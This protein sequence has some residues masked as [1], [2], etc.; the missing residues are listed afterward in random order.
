MTYETLESILRVTGFP[1]TYHHWAT[2]PQPPYL[3]YLD[4]Y[5]DNFGADDAVYHEVTHFLIELYV[6]QRDRDL[7][8]KVEAALD[9]AG[10][11]WNRIS[12][13]IE[14]EGLYQLS[15]EIEV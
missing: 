10:L 6:L 7:E 9:A 4:D 1:I 14:E 5:T 8:R 15:Y 2:P 12:A 13:Y 11:Y 3:I